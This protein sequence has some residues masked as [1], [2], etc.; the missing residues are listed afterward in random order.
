MKVDDGVVRDMRM[1]RLNK[2]SKNT[3]PALKKMV[4]EAL[5]KLDSEHYLSEMPPSPKKKRYEVNFD[6]KLHPKI[7]ELAA[8]DG[9]SVK[10]WMES[11]IL[12]KLRQ[13]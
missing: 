4:E 12:K 3:S 13:K 1:K 11:Q 8:K 9:R 6:R 2:V 7:K 5:D 10:G